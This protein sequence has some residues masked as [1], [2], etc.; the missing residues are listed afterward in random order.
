[1]SPTLLAESGPARFDEPVVD[2]A[3]FKPPFDQLQASLGNRLPTPALDL[4]AKRG[5]TYLFVR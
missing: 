1:M 4:L 3:L 2:L 5:I